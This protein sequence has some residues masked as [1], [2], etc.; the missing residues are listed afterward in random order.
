[1]SDAAQGEPPQHEVFSK[2]FKVQPTFEFWNTP[3]NYRGYPGGKDL[4]DKIKV[5]R[6]QNTGKTYGSVVSRSYGFED[7]PDAEILTPGFNEGKECGAVGVGRHGNFLQ[8]GFSGSPPQMTE[9]GRRLFLN[10]ICYIHKFDG[11]LP[12]VRVKASQRTVAIVLAMVSNRITDPKFRTRTFPAELLEKSKGDADALAK[13]YQDNLELIYYD[14]KFE[15][16]GDLPAMGLQSNRRLATLQRLIGL[17]GDP[18]HGAA[19]RKALT[20]YTQERFETP[21]EWQDWFKKN[22]DRIYFTDAGGY[23]FLVMPEGYPARP[24]SLPQP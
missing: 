13:I 14:R 19:A 9:A 24:N 12:L 2:P 3:R 16:D 21:P 5:W 17:L 6:V 10:C 23:K 11:K 20:R 15:I 22:R 18:Q 8:W 1:M 4:P 7:S